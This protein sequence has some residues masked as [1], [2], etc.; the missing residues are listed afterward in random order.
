M[1]YKLRKSGSGYFVV[2]Q[3]SGRKLS[4]KPLSRSRAV[5]QM[6]AV[7]ALE[8]G[9]SLDCSKPRNQKYITCQK[10]MRSRKVGSRKIKR[11]RK[12]VRK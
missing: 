6:R 1:P 2:N 8:G 10:K 3:K 7:Y 12:S 11:S 9:Y 4:K 5:A